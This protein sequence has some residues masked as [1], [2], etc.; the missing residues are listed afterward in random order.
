MLN[1]RRQIDAASAS[2]NLT[3]PAL[4]KKCGLERRKAPSAPEIETGWRKPKGSVHESLSARRGRQRLL[5]EPSSAGGWRSDIARRFKVPGAP[6]LPTGRPM[7]RQTLSDQ[8]R[9]AKE[10]R[11]G[12]DGASEPTVAAAF[13]LSSKRAPRVLSEQHASPN[14]HPIRCLRLSVEASPCTLHSQRVMRPLRLIYNLFNGETPMRTRTHGP[15][16]ERAA[17]DLRPQRAPP[18]RAPCISHPPG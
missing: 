18:I 2:R 5:V 4:D 16:A 12:S 15:K 13:D 9:P 1:A 6:S 14:S 10:F 11:V 3:R 17:Y 8:G 7:V